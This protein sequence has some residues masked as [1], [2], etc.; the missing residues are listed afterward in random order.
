MHGKG[1]LFVELCFEIASK[2]KYNDNIM[3][4]LKILRVMT[5]MIQFAV[6]ITRRGVQSPMASQCKVL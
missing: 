6:Y 4:G 3:H 2:H 5:C 1:D